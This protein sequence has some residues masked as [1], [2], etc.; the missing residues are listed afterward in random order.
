MA[1]GLE[2]EGIGLLL[3]TADEPDGRKAAAEQLAKL[4][5]RAPAFV[6]DGPMKSFKRALNPAWKGAIPSTFLFDADGALLCS[7]PDRCSSTRSSQSC[8]RSSPG[9]RSR[10]RRWW[11]RTRRRAD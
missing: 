5:Y 6:V 7:G 8:R 2:G 11:S 9:S 10:G 1:K 4:E 3:V